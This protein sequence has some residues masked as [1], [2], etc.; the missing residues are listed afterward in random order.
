M[1][2]F[3]WF[4]A[5]FSA[6]SLD[7]F[8][9]SM[10]WVLGGFFLHYFFKNNNFKRFFL[11]TYF[12]VLLP[13]S[14][15]EWNQISQDFNNK[16]QQNQ[17]TPLNVAGVYNITFLMSS[18]GSLAG[19]PQ[20]G[21]EMIYFAIPAKIKSH[22][23]TIQSDF[24]MKSEKVRGYIEKHID[25]QRKTSSFYLNWTRAEHS[26]DSSR[27]ALALNG[28]SILYVRKKVDKSGK[29]YHECEIVTNFHMNNVSTRIKLG[30]ITIL[31]LKEGV[32][33]AMQEKGLFSKYIVRRK[34][35]I[36]SKND[37]SSFHIFWLDDVIQ[38]ILRGKR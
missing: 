35:K 7:L 8:M 18:I 14:F 2:L 32:F 23:I 19:Y 37:L 6:L 15:F 9:T 30:E 17:Y 25:S 28:A 26:S 24:A 31:E 36:T 20:T 12:L 27:V 21:F 13:F 33:S 3:A 34:W 1:L 38:K 4:Y 10:L 11:L 5:L 22:D 16:A 29:T